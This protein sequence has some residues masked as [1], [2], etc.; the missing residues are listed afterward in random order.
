MT[1]PK[2][3]RIDH[4]FIVEPKEIFQPEEVTSKCARHAGR[5]KLLSSA[6]HLQGICRAHA[7]HMQ[8][9]S[10]VRPRGNTR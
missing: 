6:R 3:F 7:G 8:G 5:E 2:T 9:S 4:H 1:P 10:W